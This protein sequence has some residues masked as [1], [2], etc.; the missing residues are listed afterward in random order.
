MAR[1]STRRP[2]ARARWPCQS[3]EP[4]EG[5][6]REASSAA[7]RASSRSSSSAARRP[8][9]VSASTAAGLS[10]SIAGRSSARAPVA[11]VGEVR[12]G[13]VDRIGDPGGVERGTQVRAASMQERPDDPSA[14]RGDAPHSPQPAAAYKGSRIVSARSSAVWPVAMRASGPSAPGHPP[15]E[16]GSAPG[17]PHPRAIGAPAAAM[18]ATSTRRTSAG[19]P[20]SA[21]LAATAPA[22]AADSGAQ[23]MV[24]VGDGEAPAPACGER[25]RAVEQGRRIG[26]AGDGEDDGRSIG[27]GSLR[28]MFQRRHD[29]SQGICTG[30]YAIPGPGS[31]APGAQGG[32][33]GPVVP[34]RRVR[35]RGQRV[36]IGSGGRI[37]TT[38]Q[39]LMS[40]LLYH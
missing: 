14:T 1:R 11:R 30:W 33:I 24:E 3:I 22:S 13:R 5:S 34:L 2:R 19:S 26:A 16:S 18:A 9:R 7:A 39:G 6:R 35:A 32:L 31:A 36:R 4:S 37:R 29:G 12:V 15:R 17:D 38:D 21:A 8:K 20:S 27:D 25:D 10:R 28:S 40:P 23:R